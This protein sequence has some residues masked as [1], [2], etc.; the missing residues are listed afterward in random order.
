M[1][2]RDLRHCHALCQ[3][4]RRSLAIADQIK[5]TDAPT[6][7]VGFVMLCPCS[8]AALYSGLLMLLEESDKSLL[9]FARACRDHVGPGVAIGAGRCKASHQIQAPVHIMAQIRTTHTH[10]EGSDAMACELAPICLHVEQHLKSPRLPK[11]CKSAC[12]PQSWA[13]HR[14]MISTHRCGGTSASASP[15]TNN[16]GTWGRDSRI[17]SANFSSRGRNPPTKMANLGIGTS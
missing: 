5:V 12:E 13:L 3:S 8:C 1:P 14:V 9:R 15:M 2:Q 6:G 10:R 7:V 17:T 11:H 16:D 4:L